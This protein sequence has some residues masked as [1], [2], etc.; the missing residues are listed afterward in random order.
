HHLKP[1][2][3][4]NTHCHIDH[5][6]GNRFVAETYGLELT[7]PK[8]EEGVLASAPQLGQ[9]FGVTCAP[10][11][12]AGQVLVEGDVVRF[13]NSE[14]KVISTPGHS[15]ASVCFYS[16]EDRLM[17]SGDVLFLG[18][19]GRTDLPGG[20]YEVLMASIRDKLLPLGDDLRILP[21]HGPAT[22]IGAERAGNPFLQDLK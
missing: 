8:G 10:S 18:S 21:G 4:L 22:T 16:E 6:F 13:G 14:L 9:M 11:P 20:S 12:E 3:L 1:V 7:I 17:I 15:P 19:I 5:V 2:L